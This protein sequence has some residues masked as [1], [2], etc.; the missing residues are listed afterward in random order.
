[1]LIRAGRDPL[2]DKRHGS[3]WRHRNARRG[4]FS[5]IA[6]I[7]L[8]VA[9]LATA[10]CSSSPGGT[11]S[12]A[13]PN[14]LYVLTDDMAL[15]DLQYMPHV[16]EL[17]VGQGMSFT[18]YFDSN[19]LCCPARTAILRGQYSHDDG[20]WSNGGTTGGFET[21]KRNG[22]E[23]QTMATALQAGG[24]K[25]GLFGKY[26]NGY[27]NTVGKDYIPPGWDSWSSAVI[28]NAYTEY[29]Y[30]L[31]ENG[32]LVAYGQGDEDYGTT[33]YARQARDFMESASKAGKPFFAYLPVYAPHEPAQ[34]DHIDQKQYTDLVAPRSPNYNETDVSDKPNWIK[35]LLPLGEKE[36]TAINKLYKLRIQSLQSVD[37]EVDATVT[38][39]RDLGQLDNTYIVFSSDNGFHLGAHRMQAGKTTAYEEDIH[40]PLVIRGPGIAAGS[41]NDAMTGNIDVAPTF[42]DLAGTKLA[43]DP[44]G[45]SLV[46]L[47]HGQTPPSWRQ[48]YLLEHRNDTSDPP[49]PGSG[50][51][52]PPLP[53]SAPDG[54]ASAPGPGASDSPPSRDGIQLEP[55]DPDQGANDDPQAAL[56]SPVVFSQAPTTTKPAASNPAGG[57][58]GGDATEPGAASGSNRPGVAIP[59]FAGI[60]VAGYLYVEY[61]NDRAEFYDLTKDPYELD[62]LNQSADPAL[63]SAFHD[64]LQQL[65]PCAGQSCRSIEDQPL[66]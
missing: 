57:G 34:P 51:V 23:K 63:I 19:S 37:R 55:P 10:A 7:L 21:F 6:P 53:G 66:P 45:R 62:N 39:L 11:A 42:V 30:T 15:D 38:K 48:A 65:T 43:Y 2:Q 8:T 31:N 59:R 49:A 26:L 56:A 50:P 47:L 44:D 24:Y 20:V 35:R 5:A 41:T 14:I 3:A 60:R 16:K 52:T 27:P 32:K 13:K 40:L 61:L 46:P 12:G 29:N 1:M 18:N 22:A 17:L 54:A 4:R 33:V 28:G 9:I 25:T 58:E 36:D 64:R